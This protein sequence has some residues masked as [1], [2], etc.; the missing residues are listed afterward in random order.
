MQSRLEPLQAPP[1]ADPRKPPVT[2]VFEQ[3][4]ATDCRDL[5]GHLNAAFTCSARCLGATAAAK[6]PC[7]AELVIWQRA[8]AGGQLH[9]DA[10]MA[11]AGV[12]PAC[13]LIVIAENAEAVESDLLGHNVADFVVRPYTSQELILRARR[14]MGLVEPVVATGERAAG[15]KIEAIVVGSSAALAKEVDKLK[16]FA[17][18]DAGVLILG[19]TGTGKEVF[20]QATHYVSARAA[21]PMVAINCGAVP[22]ELME[23]EL[24]GHVKGAYT[25]AHMSRTGTGVRSR[26][27]HAVPGRRRLPAA[28]GPGQAAA[29]PAGAR[30]PRR[31]LQYGPAC[32]RARDRRLQP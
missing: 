8:G 32:R 24:F 25:N 15:G 5:I 9:T 19:E 22:A 28:V 7:D 4:D 20:A 26:A 13:P 31:R 21:K 2:V 16:R 30:V 12:P 29:L 17:A 23:A 18:C 27:R 10:A 14:V 6:P 11:L 1:S 3:N